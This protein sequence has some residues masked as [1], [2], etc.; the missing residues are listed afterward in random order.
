LYTI[1][2]EVTVNDDHKHQQVDRR[3]EFNMSIME[4]LSTH[5][6]RNHRSYKL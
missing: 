6:H 1:P 4:R 5:G 3:D 2:S